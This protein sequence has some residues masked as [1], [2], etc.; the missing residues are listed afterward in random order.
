MTANAQIWP[1]SLNSMLGGD[2]DKI[3]LVTADMG[4]NSGSGLD[5]IGEFRVR[6]PSPISVAVRWGSSANDMLDGL[7]GFAFLQ[8]FYSV[9][10]TGNS[11]VG[12]ATTPYTD[13]TTN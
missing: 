12:F 13:A 10:D 3:Y 9:F 6:F 8:R 4:V 1:R 2:A 5:F 7:D 11:Q